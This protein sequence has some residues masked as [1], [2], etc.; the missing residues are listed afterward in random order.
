MVRKGKDHDLHLQDINHYLQIGKHHSNT[1][2][3]KNGIVKARKKFMLGDN[4]KYSP[5]YLSYG[6]PVWVTPLHDK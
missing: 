6:L 5:D 2:I 1:S 4:G 3:E